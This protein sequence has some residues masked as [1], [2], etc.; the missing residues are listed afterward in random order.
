M[1]VIFKLIE[2]LKNIF[3]I[4]RNLAN[5]S[6]RMNNLTRLEGKLEAL[7][8]NLIDLDLES[9]SIK[10]DKVLQY[11]DVGSEFKSNEIIE[12][13]KSELI[14]LIHE[15]FENQFLQIESLL[16]I[17]NSLPNLK[18]LPATRGWAGSPDFLAKIVEVII[19]EKPLFV[20][21][22]S[23]G[24]STLIIGLALK[25]NNYGTSISLDHELTYAKITNENIEVNEIEDLSKVVYCPLR[26]YNNF[27]QILKWYETDNLIFTERID[28]LIIDGPPRNIQFLARYPAV[29]LLYRHFADNVIIIL[30]DSNRDDETIIIQKWIEF[31]ENKNFKV[32]VDKFKNYEK[33]MVI[34][35]VCKGDV[36]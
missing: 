3:S 16:T 34:M 26:D 22:A 17:Y 30:D 18:F 28:L 29:P 10:L 5:F 15:R 4:P 6:L 19:K 24:V 21:E 9:I 13:F 36:E 1:K 7:N 8:Q 27:N 14:S 33:G 32:K 20:L 23:S 35:R 2:V 31:L 12:I 25:M 11:Q